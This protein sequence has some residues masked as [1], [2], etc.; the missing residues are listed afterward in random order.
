MDYHDNSKF[1]DITSVCWNG[2]SSVCGFST[3]LGCIQ[4][5]DFKKREPI[6]LY[7]K[8]SVDSIKSI[9]FSPFNPNTLVSACKDGSVGVYNMKSQEFLERYWKIH[10]NKCTDIGFSSYQPDLVLSCSL[11]ET[12]AFLD[13]RQKKVANVINLNTP[14]N[15]LSVSPEGNYIVLGSF[16]GDILGIDIRKSASVV[17]KY[18]G[19]TAPVKKIDYNSTPSS[20]RRKT[21]SYSSTKDKKYVSEKMHRQSNP[22]KLDK[23]PNKSFRDDEIVSPILSK[24][25]KIRKETIGGGSSFDQNATVNSEYH[26]ERVSKKVKF[27]DSHT[28]TIQEIKKQ[29][30]PSPMPKISQLQNNLNTTVSG[31]NQADKDEIKNFIRSE[32]NSLRLDF[33]KE[34]ELQRQEMERM[35]TNFTIKDKQ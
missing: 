13:L 6:I 19:H 32:I 10:N 28:D 3:S 17:M 33:I 24:K 2:G 5:I 20:F 1:L 23:A 7:R 35:F 29:I 18:K 15:C 11:D 14:L 31:M 16:F 25:S 12:M 4:I 21:E 27:R 8:N 22:V 34:L 26:M 30:Q 9:K